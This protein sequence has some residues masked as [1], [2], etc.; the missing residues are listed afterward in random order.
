M[1]RALAWVCALILAC[2]ACAEEILPQETA[3]M[4]LESMFAAMAGTDYESEAALQKDMPQEQRALRQDELASYREITRPWLLAALCPQGEW[5]APESPLIEEELTA[6][7]P[8]T[9]ISPEER[10]YQAMM[11]NPWG[12][13]YLNAM[14]EQGA[15]DAESGLALTRSWLN[16]WLET[17]DVE[18][19]RGINDDYACWL[20]GPA[21][22]MD[23]P[24]VQGEDNDYYLDRL[25]NGARNA[26]GT[27]FIDYRNLPDF[28]DPNT[29][30]YGHHMRND[31]MFG[32]L[33][34]YEYAGYFE[35]H[36][37]LVLFAPEKIYLL[38]ALAGYTTSK[39][40]HCY[41]IAISGQEDFDRFLAEARQKSDFAAQVTAVHGENLA[42]LSTCAYAFENARYI[43]IARLTPTAERILPDVQ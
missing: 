26:C 7:D 43:L 39:H 32:S 42:T 4:G 29:L 36:P 23:Y 40:D 1:R 2:S 19:F 14:A 41:D 16:A 35:S 17:V 28:Q 21:T 24:V 38:E 6:V 25:F 18:K 31:S 37:Y 15:S 9:E 22:L 13:A 12:Q 5:A 8:E 11:D 27:L 20:L 10:A 30:I 3:R 33:T 34:E